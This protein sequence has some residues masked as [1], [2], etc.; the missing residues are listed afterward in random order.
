MKIRKY[1]NLILAIISL[2]IVMI[3][4]GAYQTI[5]LAKAHSTFDNYYTFRG[6]VKLLD[7][8]DDYGVCQTAAGETV[9][10]V[11]FDNR[12]FLDGDLPCGFLCF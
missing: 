6:C 11:K 1:K 2:A 12:W 8:T 9:K 7:R 3:I 5:M 4:L 10:I